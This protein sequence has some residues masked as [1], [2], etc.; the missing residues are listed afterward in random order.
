MRTYKVR[1]S[2]VVT[3][4]LTVYAENED[5][6]CDLAEDVIV[7]G[8]GDEIERFYD[9]EEMEETGDMDDDFDERDDHFND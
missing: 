1:M 8:N 6:A 9:L 2:E 4:E 5:E 3:Y 7:H